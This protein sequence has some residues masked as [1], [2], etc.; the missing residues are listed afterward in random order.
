MMANDQIFPYV[1]CEKK[2][3]S[4]RNITLMTYARWVVIFYL[5]KMAAIVYL[6]MPGPSES[7]AKPPETTLEDPMN[8]RQLATTVRNELELLDSS[9]EREHTTLLH[10]IQRLESVEAKDALE[11]NIQIEVLARNALRSGYPDVQKQAGIALRA[12]ATRNPRTHGDILSW[13]ASWDYRGNDTYRE[14]KLEIAILTKPSTSSGVVQRRQIL[15]STTREKK[16]N[17]LM[18]S[19]PKPL[20]KISRKKNALD[21]ES[22]R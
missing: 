2:A 11:Q 14:I 13:L 19:C 4:R 18:N 20:R 5:I 17:L 8:I 10:A 22:H 7:L 16:T 1:C 6:L 12:I 21:T 9:D 3:S 15:V